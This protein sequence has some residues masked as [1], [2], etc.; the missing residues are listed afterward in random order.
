MT[1]TTAE[2]APGSVSILVGVDFEA[3]GEWAFEEAARVAK[4]I[5]HAEL[6]VVHVIEAH[7]TSDVAQQAASRLRNFVNE[8]AAGFGG[9]R[10]V[11]VGIH[12]RVGHAAEAIAAVSADTR[13][14]LVILGSGKASQLKSLFVGSTAESVVA[15]VSCPVFLAGPAPSRG[16]SVPSIEPPCPLCLR[17]RAESRGERW[18]CERHSEHH[19]RAHAYSYQRELPFA[20]H[21]SEVIPTGIAPEGVH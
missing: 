9:L 3:P 13:A 10:G 4:D 14:N 21:D 18:W 15:S 12:V 11:R 16:S 5:P 2:R 8:R 7:V 20:Q 1:D 19:A 6:H 17:A